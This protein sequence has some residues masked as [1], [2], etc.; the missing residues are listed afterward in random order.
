MTTS[1]GDVDIQPRSHA[2]ATTL[3]R[4]AAAATV[5]GIL[6]S[7]VLIS[8]LGGATFPGLQPYQPWSPLRGIVAAQGLFGAVESARGTE[9]KDLVFHASTV[10]LLGLATLRFLLL[11]GRG[12]RD[13]L[14]EP[15]FHGQMLLGC[16]VILSFW[17]M[18]WSG[19]PLLSLG[20]ATLYLYFLGF[21]LALAYTLERRHV[22]TVVCGLAIVSIVA[23]ILCIWYFIER[24]P[25]HRPGFP[26]GNPNT[27]SIALAPAILLIAAIRFAPVN[28]VTQAGLVSWRAW[29][30]PA[31]VP[32]LTCLWLTRGRAALIALTVGLALLVYLRTGKRTRWIVGMGTG[33]L[34]AGAGLWLYFF[35]TQDLTM[36]R[37]A[38]LRYRLYAWR[39]AAEIWQ[40]R[41]TTGWGA[42]AYPRLA[43]QYATYDRALD[44]A[45]FMGEIIS[46]A[47]N[48]LFEVF[49]EIG[50]VG[51]V[52]Y[53][54]GF[55]AV[56]VAAIAM[57]R[58]T[59]DARARILM[60]GL[61]A[62][63]VAL[64]IDGCFSAALRLPGIP[65]MLATTLGLIWALCRQQA[66]DEAPFG[67]GVR[68]PVRAI[69]AIASASVAIYLAT[70][71]VQ[72]WTGVRDEVAAYRAF[73]QQNHQLAVRRAEQAAVRLLDP[74]RALYALDR[75][76]WASLSAAGEAYRWSWAPGPDG[77]PVLRES[78]RVAAVEAAQTAWEH[79]VVL[80]RIA[81]SWHRIAVVCARSAELLMEL[82]AP[83]APDRA[84]EWRVR[85]EG[86]WR[87]QRQWL[88]YDFETL[89]A[90]LH[91]SPNVQEQVGLLRDSLAS[92]DF[93]RAAFV[94]ALRDIRTRPGF[95]EA[96]AR[97]ERGAGPI[98]P[99]TDTD[100][101][102][103]SGA[104]QTYRL[105]A[106]SQ[107]L[108]GDPARAAE[109]AARATRLYAPLRLRF[110]TLYSEALREEAVYRFAS[111][112]LNAA[113]CDDLI[114]EAIEKLPRIQEQQYERLVLPFR[115]D[116]V[117]Y[118]LAAGDE[119]GAIPEI[120]RLARTEE[121]IGNHLARFYVD[122]ASVGIPADTPATQIEQWLTKAIHH[123]P[124][125]VSAWTLRIRRAAIDGDSQRATALLDAAARAGVPADALA[126][127][128]AQLP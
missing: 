64:L 58:R 68:G 50:L 71:T 79:A 73:E 16:W 85:A 15:W 115:I 82:E 76:A 32:L 84:R 26:L 27:L 48:E 123:D 89:L 77:T 81:P 113:R 63:L 126:Q 75:R 114:A 59:K 47:H 99:E 9:I 18:Q 6:G 121:P 124:D 110:A 12:L 1:S 108:A 74:V 25:H 13:A 61:L 87:L 41:P 29:T 54:G 125:N 35:S 128:R 4:I 103:A 46:H 92:A 21:A 122:L 34:V 33:L 38:T 116:L 52:T 44:P 102:I 86:A 28:E 104:P 83:T 19:A 80:M 17:S 14:W 24:N 95:E 7:F 53:V 98:T 78:N 40:Q 37:G 106:A 119:A 88:L 3:S 117:R 65:L 20:Q 22:S 42:G 70:T 118:R 55:V 105:L 109:S 97:L 49:A 127:L 51:G 57:L 100:S 69:A 43:G 36:G 90:L 30:I 2:A 120:E 60:S 11:P 91:Y 31:L 5:L 45:A 72:N 8:P 101:L 62:G 66:T 39:Y 112:W 94:D 23:A 67:L 93:R 111:S 96:L 10:L 56:L 107:A